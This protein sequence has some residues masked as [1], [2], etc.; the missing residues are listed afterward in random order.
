MYHTYH[1]EALTLS[2]LPRGEADRLV[3]FFT[4]DLGLVRAIARG[5]RLER[6]KM[7]S[8][9]QDFS[10]VHVSLIRGKEMWRVVGTREITNFYESLCCSREKVAIVARIYSLVTRL[11]VGEERN[12]LLYRSLADML[13]FLTQEE[14]TLAECRVAEHLLAL[15]VLFSLGYVGRDPVYEA[16]VGNNIVSRTSILEASHHQNVIV[17]AINTALTES[18]M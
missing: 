3:T 13:T 16:Y 1:T 5:V 14:L 17:R 12:N 15:R 18:Q 10:L 7:R 9:L 2:S 6:S 4:E 11:V 8:T